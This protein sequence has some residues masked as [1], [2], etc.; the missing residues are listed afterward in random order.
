MRRWATIWILLLCC[1]GAKA[2]EVEVSF[3]DSKVEVEQ[4]KTFKNT[5]IVKNKGEDSTV[6]RLE[7]NL[8]ATGWEL[9]AP[10]D[11]ISLGAGEQ[12]RLPLKYMATAELLKGEHKISYTFITASGPLEAS[13]ALQLQEL[14]QVWIVKNQETLL[15]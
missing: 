2:Q 7:K 1:W 5:L 11:S 13:F 4:G 10:P 6:I 14:A 8:A 15:L 3:Q 9:L 12:K